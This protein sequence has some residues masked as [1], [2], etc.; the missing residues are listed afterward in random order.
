VSDTKPFNVPT[1]VMQ[2]LPAEQERRRSR[3]RKV[4]FTDLTRA[5]EFLDRLEAAGYEGRSL[6]VVGG[7]FVVR[8]RDEVPRPAPVSDGNPLYLVPVAA[9][10]VLLWV[11]AGLG[12]A[13]LLR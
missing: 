2:P 8:W 5:A 10:A 1:A 9:V 4:V 13:A 7:A 11:A 6:A 12:V 3:W